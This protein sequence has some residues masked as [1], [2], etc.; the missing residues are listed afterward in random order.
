M[1]RFGV[2][3]DTVRDAVHSLQSEGLV[4]PRRGAGTIVLEHHNDDPDTI[5]A[6]G[7]RIRREA[8]IEILNEL[9][10]DWEK[11]ADSSD[12]AFQQ[13]ADLLRAR[14][15]QIRQGRPSTV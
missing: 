1:A 15:V 8:Q 11:Q 5:A 9:A 13:F 2:A 3:R 12:S 7:P 10:D 6:A 4:F 14:V